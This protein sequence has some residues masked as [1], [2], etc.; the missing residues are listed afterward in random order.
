MKPYPPA[1]P[2]VNVRQRL[3]MAG[4]AFTAT[5]SIVCALLLSFDAASPQIWLMPTPELLALS[6]D[7]EQR[8]AREARDHCKQQM[9]AAR[10]MPDPQTQQVAR[11]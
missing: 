6:L 4:A 10:L 5:T 3:C 2:L 9:V 1:I 7:C 11:R 8:P